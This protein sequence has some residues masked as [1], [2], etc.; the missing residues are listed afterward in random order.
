MVSSVA[1]QWDDLS[2]SSTSGN[3]T[4]KLATK[5]RRDGGDLLKKFHAL[6]EAETDLSIHEKRL[7]EIEVKV[8]LER[9]FIEQK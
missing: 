3:L 7:C 9:P 8:K 5:F 2:V 6:A 4:S 1:S